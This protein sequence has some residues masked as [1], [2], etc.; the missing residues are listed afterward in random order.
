MDS[1]VAEISGRVKAGTLAILDERPGRAVSAAY[2]ALAAA[3]G[4][5]YIVADRSESTTL[6]HIADGSGRNVADLGLALENVRTLV[7]F[8]APVLESWATP[9]RVLT[10]WKQKQLAIVQVEADLSKTAALASKWLPVRAGSEASIASFLAGKIG[11]AE[12]AQATGVPS[13]KLADAMRFIHDRGPWLAVSGGGFAQ[14]VEQSIAGLNA[15]SSAVVARAASPAPGTRLSQLPNGSVDVLLV[16]HGLLGGSVP[17]DSLRSK[18]RPDGIIVSLSP[19]RAGVAALANFVI[20]TPAFAESLDEAPT[21]W[22]A[23]SPSYA[24]APAILD[25]PAGVTTA[26]EFINRV[27]GA[28]AAPEALIRAK[29]EGLYTAK[30]GDVFTF[31][32][33]TTKPV[34]EFK[35]STD[36]YKAFTTGACWIDQDAKVVAINYHADHSATRPFV[37]EPRLLRSGCAISPPLFTKLTQESRLGRA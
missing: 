29:V 20:P 22:D 28:D 4:G 17:Y 16:D 33:R 5:L 34:T 25:P 8:G 30:R 2:A 14:A 23:V 11:I 1:V 26:L 35:S 9:G 18:L 3:H 21:P 32:D 31:A 19:Y 27:T 7:S 10:P 37:S 13:D 6:Q 12:A 24:L 15:G 36:L